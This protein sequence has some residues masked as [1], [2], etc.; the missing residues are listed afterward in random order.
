MTGNTILAFIAI[1]P[2]RMWCM[3]VHQR[4]H[5]CTHADPTLIK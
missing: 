4:T 1:L 5:A 2:K 3:R